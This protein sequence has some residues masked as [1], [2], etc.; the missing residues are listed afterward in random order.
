M[1]VLTLLLTILTSRMWIDWHK[2]A[3][4]ACDPFGKLIH[5]TE[6][7]CDEYFY[8]PHR[9]ETRG[10]GGIFLMISMMEDLKKTIHS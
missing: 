3:K 8:L 6:N 10:V 5:Q 4:S 2:F 9:R 1:A 7:W